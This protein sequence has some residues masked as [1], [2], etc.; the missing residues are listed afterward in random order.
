[1][2]AKPTEPPAQLINLQEGL[3]GPL[4]RS[5]YGLVR[6]PLESFLEVSALNSLYLDTQNQKNED[7][8]FT[9]VLRSFKVDY[10]VSSEDLA[11][12]PRQGPL[13]VVA[14]HPYGGMDGMVLA[15]LLSSVRP[16]VKWI[17]N[18]LLLR[19]PELRDWIFPVDP[20]NRPGSTRQ[21]IKGMKDAIRHLRAGG[22]LA[23]F[24]SGTVSHIQVRQRQITDPP[25]STHVARLARAAEA[26]VVP[27]YFEGNNSAL[28]QI[29]GLLHPLLRTALLPR[30]MVRQC[31]HTIHLRIGPPIPFCRLDEFP[32]DDA[33]TE[34]LRLSTY[35]LRNRAGNAPRR[36]FP[37]SLDKLTEAKTRRK[38]ATMAPPVSPVDLAK[39]FAGL[40]PEQ[41]LVE[42][43]PYAVA[44]AKAAQIPS[45]MLEI[46]RLREV[47][48]REV[49]EGSGKQRDQ[50]EFDRYY[51]HLF[52]WDRE[53]QAIVGA[54]RFALSDEVL[55]EMGPKGFYTSTLFKYK[56][57]FFETLDPAMELGRSFIV[58]AYQ[59]KQAAL[60]LIWRGLGQFI[61]N[62][63][64][65]KTLFGPVSI[66]PDYQ[67][68]S[69]DLM[70]QFLRSHS[71]DQELST[72]VSPKRPHRQSK[73]RGA[74]KK[75][76]QASACDIDNISAL[77]SE[78]E[79]DKKGVPVLLRHYLK[80]NGRLVSFNEDPEFGSCLDGLI[81]VDLTKSDPKLLKA[82]MGAE[83]A[84]RFLT[85]HRP[86]G[87][88]AGTGMRD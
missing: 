85:F 58:S 55:P 63:P 9:R 71:I 12:I 56:A 36:R 30:E 3:R 54:Y 62:N 13:V 48:F 66:N 21:N 15:A 67:T 43:A 14:N 10:E 86:L 51:R 5:L 2:V 35:L 17:S 39:D 11:R 8:F 61:A 60:A 7:N 49:N 18:Y 82:H 47:T 20:F 22:C 31:S 28:F 6:E 79:T 40:P 68:L 16:D 72:L 4:K 84:E 65:Y 45:I 88:L 81:I 46:A 38:L 50:D 83:G 44:Y 34:F 76:V 27:V 64:R 42:H 19:V 26:S 41:I 87:E 32:T 23:T 24:P 75:A 77:I 59:R 73:L 78:I 80:L 74:E 69:K 70:V 33:M 37:L 1:M 29:A 25:W 57:D 53:K 52:M